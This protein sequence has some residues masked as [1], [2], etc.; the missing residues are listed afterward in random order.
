[1]DNVIVAI[2]PSTPGDFMMLLMTAAARSSYRAESAVT[3]E[4]EMEGGTT[5]DR[6]GGLV[7]AATLKIICASSRRVRRGLRL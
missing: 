7:L 4:I 5:T 3:E 2:I 1:M 6:T